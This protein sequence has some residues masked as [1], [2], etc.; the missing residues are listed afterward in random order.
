MDLCSNVLPAAYRK[1][2]RN[3]NREAS[4]F[5]KFL[6]HSPPLVDIPGL[7]GQLLAGRGPE[8]HRVFT[9]RAEPGADLIVSKLTVTQMAETIAN[10]R[11]TMPAFANV[12]K[13]EQL[14]DVAGY[15]SKRL[16]K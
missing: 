12:F 9:G 13:P 5:E 6:T 11:N 16:A 4:T 14:R 7:A 2:N 15:V 10:G 8:L 1:K 3:I